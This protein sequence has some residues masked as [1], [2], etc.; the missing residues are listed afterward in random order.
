MRNRTRRAKPSSLSSFAMPGGLNEQDSGEPPPQGR[1]CL[2]VVKVPRRIA[3]QGQPTASHTLSSDPP[4]NILKP[5][6]SLN[7][8]SV[9]ASVAFYANLFGTQGKNHRPGHASFDLSAPSLFLVLDE[10]P[11]TGVNADHFGVLL[12]WESDL[13]E[14]AVRLQRAGI[15][16]T[17]ER[18]K[19]WSRDPDGNDWEFFVVPSK[20]ASG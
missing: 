15:T 7:V 4:M 18:F 2:A 19:I 11:R 10:K 3:T 6:V 1:R 9:E 13:D 8:A 5:H 17:R 16:S 12:A 14:A 20:P